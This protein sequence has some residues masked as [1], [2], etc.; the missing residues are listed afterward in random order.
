MS[1][2]APAAAAPPAPRGRRWW[3]HAGILIVLVAVGIV[4]LHWLLPPA[5]VADLVLGQ[6]GRTLALDIRRSGDADYR[7][8]GG[9]MLLVHDIVVRA[10][11]PAGVPSAG[12]PSPG[13]PS[14]GTSALLRADRV[15]IALPWR[16]LLSRGKTLAITRI[17][18]DR[19]ILDLPAVQQWL[20]TRPPG[21]SRLPTLVDGLRIRDGVLHNGPWRVE[22]IAVDLPRLAPEAADARDARVDARV[23]ARLRGR[24]VD[25]TMR[26]PFDVA[27]AM[28]RPGNGAGAAVVG[29]ISI[30]RDDRRIPAWVSLSGPLLFGD[31]NIRVRPARLGLHASVVSGDTRMPFALGLQGP[32]RFD[33]ATWTLAPLGMALHGT[34]MLPSLESHGA[35]ALGRRLVVRLDGRMQGWPDAWPA[36]PPPLS[37]SDAP[38]T[39]GMR[40]A[41][42]ADLSGPI[43][44]Q[45][46]R[47]AT[48][49]D[50]RFHV[51][52]ISGWL[53]QLERGTPLPPLQ[54]RIETPG[55]EISGARLEGVVVEFED[56]ALDE[57]SDPPRPDNSTTTTTTTP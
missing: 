4:L 53:A 19:P 56:A 26:I 3:R 33:G 7:L 50:G 21:D 10:P 20:A 13:A 45:L 37:A 42:D 2:D 15:Y 46:Q 28:T 24:Y 38:F 49:F 48:R 11:S 52:D 55:I 57:G 40:Y 31:G 44:L 5:R 54:G 8:R 30:E 29:N 9:P 35:I 18:L 47:D 27:V 23:D 39:F 51:A 17:E 32:L 6:L 12:V 25:T 1:A 16:T 14:S 41:D 36:L 22:G 43:G 34:Q